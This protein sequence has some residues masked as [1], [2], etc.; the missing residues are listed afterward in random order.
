MTPSLVVSRSSF[1]EAHYQTG[2]T[3]PRSPASIPREVSSKNKLMADGVV[4]S[5]YLDG[6]KPLSFT[7]LQ[8]SHEED[9][10][11]ARHE[12]SNLRHRVDRLLECAE[13]QN[14][15]KATSSNNK[16]TTLLQACCALSLRTRLPVILRQTAELVES[17]ITGGD[18][19][20]NNNSNHRIVGKMRSTLA[21]VR[22]EKYMDSIQEGMDADTNE[23][24]DEQ[25]LYVLSGL[26]VESLPQGFVQNNNLSFRVSPWIASALCFD[27]PLGESAQWHTTPQELLVGDPQQLPIQVQVEPVV[28]FRA[29]DAASAAAARAAAVA[30]EV[31]IEQ[32]THAARAVCHGAGVIGEATIRVHVR[33]TA[34]LSRGGASSSVWGSDNEGVQSLCIKEAR[35]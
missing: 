2:Q 28:E 1:D 17:A 4:P 21:L 26:D 3:P 20:P 27:L 25:L 24:L 29:R 19:Q 8:K 7:S 5:L 11:H 16:N 15:S 33:P 22:L 13:K 10:H 18:G 31:V 34:R 35:A 30:C 12:L 23:G 6:R 9:E 32:C 14:S